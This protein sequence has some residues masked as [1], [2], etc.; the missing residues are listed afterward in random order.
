MPDTAAGTAAPL[1][2]TPRSADAE[3]AARAARIESAAARIAS[4]KVPQEVANADASTH[5]IEH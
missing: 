5:A 3:Q 2:D 4:R 1:T